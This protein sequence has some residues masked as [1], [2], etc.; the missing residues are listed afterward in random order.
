MKELIGSEKQIAWGN[1]LR[2]AL[3]KA[4]ERTESNM[5]QFYTTEALEPIRAELR[6]IL[7]NII[8]AK[9]YIDNRNNGV[10][11]IMK[12]LSNSRNVDS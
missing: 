8:E 5:E 10:L 1:D 2:L 12:E 3:I 9:W 4:F 7:E 6:Y 11:D